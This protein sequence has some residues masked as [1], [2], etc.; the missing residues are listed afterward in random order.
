MRS[1]RS[2]SKKGVATVIAA[3]AVTGVIAVGGLVAAQTTGNVYTGCL[4]KGL[5]TKVKIGTAPLSG[6]GKATQIS[7]NEV[8][9]AGPQGPA[10]A[11]G[12][13][14]A[15][16]PQGT[17]GATGATGPQGPE[18]AP[19][20]TGPQGETGATGP[21]GERGV[22]GFYVVDASVAAPA[23][24]LT[25]VEGYVGIDGPSFGVGEFVVSCDA[26]DVAVSETVSRVNTF[27]MPGQA[28]DPSYTPQAMQ[29]VL[30]NGTPTGYSNL[31]P[32]STSAQIY[33]DGVSFE[34]YSQGIVASVTCADMT[35]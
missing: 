6:C 20:A 18:G 17:A 25:G 26:G 32:L 1:G 22:L 3:A 16:G 34:A 19:G 24:A 4:E 5:I 31:S 7:W 21:Q 27:S 35:L 14:G 13:T 33:E 23:I 12:A 9:E 15:T 8:G 10:G 2:F 29:V 28:G 30:T 11:T